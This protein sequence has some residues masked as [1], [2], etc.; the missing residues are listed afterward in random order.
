MNIYLWCFKNKFKNLFYELQRKYEFV[1][2]SKLKLSVENAS[3]GFKTWYKQNPKL[4]TSRAVS[5]GFKG[6]K[7]P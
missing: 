6:G 7:E 4:R 1:W 2:F 5:D 3:S